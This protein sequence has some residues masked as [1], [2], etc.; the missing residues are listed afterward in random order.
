MHD[1]AC[2]SSRIVCL[3]LGEGCHVSRLAYLEGFNGVRA[4]SNCFFGCGRFFYR[5]GF[6]RGVSYGFSDAYGAVKF[7]LWHG[8]V[9][10]FS[11][12][13]RSELDG[14]AEL[15]T[16]FVSIAL[17][18][19]TAGSKCMLAK[20]DLFTSF[21][22]ARN[23]PVEGAA[24]DLILRGAVVLLFGL[25]FGA[26]Y[27]WAIKR[28][29][30]PQIVNS[31]RVA[32]LSIP[33]GAILMLAIAAILGLLKISDGLKWVLTLLLIASSYAFCISTPLAAITGNR[34]LA[35][36]TKGLAKLVYFGNMVGAW[37]S[38]AAAIILLFAAFVSL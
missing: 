8:C 24:K 38:L 15:A 16:G 19:P 23:M 22:L 5:N 3:V 31:W 12:A 34:S 14:M 11:L 18:P 27:A 13:R 30:P 26:P 21:Q 28:N 29:A 10:L 35:S 25:S 6:W 36:G 1:C 9:L 33:V 32:H 17:S 37:T 4:H 20:S 7:F 2:F